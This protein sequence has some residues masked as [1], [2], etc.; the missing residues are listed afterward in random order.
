MVKTPRFHCSGTGSIPS[1]RSK[2]PA[3]PMAKNKTLDK[4]WLTAPECFYSASKVTGNLKRS[5]FTILGWVQITQSGLRLVFSVGRQQ[6]VPQLPNSCACLKLSQSLGFSAHL[7]ETKGSA[8]SSRVPNPGRRA[9][10]GLSTPK[11]EAGTWGF[12][13]TLQGLPCTVTAAAVVEG[14]V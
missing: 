5:T 12:G 13:Y 14:D 10:C 3:S 11:W 9:Q 2:I 7:G 1:H 6:E 8:F 4:M